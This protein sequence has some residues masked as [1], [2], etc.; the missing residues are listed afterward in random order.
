MSTKSDVI[1]LTELKIEIKRVSS[2][3]KHLRIRE[4]IIEERLAKYLNET[5]QP[6]VKYANT[7][8]ILQ[9]K[10]PA[11]RKKKKCQ[12][13][14]SLDVLKRHGILDTK[15]VLKELL[16]ARR[17]SPVLKQKIRLQNLNN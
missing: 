9:Q 3:L 8:I 6:G 14:D 1:E 16:E 10:T 7:A 11:S 12:E 4:K 15:Q 17:G 5:N 2:T 13:T